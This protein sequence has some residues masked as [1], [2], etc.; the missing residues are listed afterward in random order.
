MDIGNLHFLRPFWLLALLPAGWLLWRRWHDIGAGSAWQQVCDAH[1]LAHL[2][3]QRPGTH[4][5]L[6]LL[7][8]AAGWLLAII[9]LSGPVWQ[10]L[11]QITF[12]TQPARVLVLDL[13][14]A[15]NATDLKP[16]R[17]ERARFKLLDILRASGE[18]QTALV[19]FSGEPHVV[20]PL[21]E[22]TATIEAMLPALQTS[23]MPTTGDKAAPALE[24]AATL[25]QQAGAHKGD[26]LLLTEGIKDGAS[27]L[28]TVRNLKEQGYRVSVLG[29]GT[30]EG[31]PVPLRDGGFGPMSH[32]DRKAL[33]EIA[34]Q[35]GG[36]YHN[37]TA[38]NA[39]IE[40]TLSG[41]QHIGSGGRE[42]P[43]RS[44]ERWIEHGIWLLLP[45]L[46][47]AAAGN[48][49]GWLGI[50]LAT[51]LLPAPRAEAF[52]WNWL[53]L[54]QDQRATRLLQQG[55]A[56]TAAQQFTRPDW[57]AAAL[58]SAGDYDAAARAYHNLQGVEAR[59]NEGNALA[60][61]GHFRSAI[62]AYEAALAQQPDHADALAN[63]RLIEQ[64]LRKQEA[65]KA[66]QQ[67]AG[68]GASSQG[69]SKESS[70]GK[71]REGR[72]DT[73]QGSDGRKPRDEGGENR[74][75]S[76][77]QSTNEAHTEAAGTGIMPDAPENADLLGEKP[78]PSGH[79][80]PRQEADIALEQW[81]RQIP[82]DPSGLLRRKFMLEHLLRK[83]GLNTP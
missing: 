13:S 32:L 36:H 69:G 23:I 54:N 16:S 9:V 38:S 42:T 53:W 82:D 2:W 15:M 3:L 34:R 55:Q 26:I 62:K 67:H 44:L 12:K 78:T 46:L 5:R 71:E 28:N 59:Y 4:Q 83:Q 18:G 20:T 70:A 52:E 43:S 35:G 33:R 64:L 45:L 58:H 19:V 79:P 27:T 68:N 11:P 10:K 17:L 73:A 81:L 63:K 74:P 72:A 22:D 50:L 8:L 66:P 61:G 30:P 56:A 40:A 65:K 48:R 41:Y 49:R 51:F 75:D 77:G 29:I 57:Q 37:M 6:P 21:T 39:D 14:Q 25:L 24:M 7:L 31:A 76:Q 80:T 60:R 1:L 47:L